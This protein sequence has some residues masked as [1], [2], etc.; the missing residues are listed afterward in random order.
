MVVGREIDSGERDV[1]KET[2]RGSFVET[3]Q[4]EVL[5]DP[6]RRTAGNAFDVFGELALN[7]ETDFDDF[8]RIGEDLDVL[9]RC[10]GERVEKHTT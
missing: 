2:G 7:L 9:V 1:A 4:T 6:H 5:H 10:V 3:H 8:E